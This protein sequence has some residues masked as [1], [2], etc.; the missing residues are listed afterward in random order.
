MQ[1]VGT[2]IVQSVCDTECVQ[3]ETYTHCVRKYS[4]PKNPAVVPTGYGNW[5]WTTNFEASTAV[6][7][8]IQVRC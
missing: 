6:L 8:Q 4:G 7:L 1:L 2:D 5:S 3:R